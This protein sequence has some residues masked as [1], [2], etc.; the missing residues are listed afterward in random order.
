[1]EFSQKIL[2][3]QTTT[4]PPTSEDSSTIIVSSSPITEII[5]KAD[6]SP[7]VTNHKSTTTQEINADDYP[8]AI[9]QGQLFTIIENGK[10][11]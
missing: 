10:F 4:K 6:E 3:E 1:M 5:T 8:S 7:Q 9:N 2:T 11:L